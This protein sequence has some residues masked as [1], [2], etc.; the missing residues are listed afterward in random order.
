VAAHDACVAALANGAHANG[1][2][3]VS[4][5]EY[6][7]GGGMSEAG[8]AHCACTALRGMHQPGGM[9]CAPTGARPTGIAGPHT[10]GAALHALRHQCYNSTMFHNVNFQCAN[11]DAWC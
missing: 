5:A 6:D 2:A 10:F 8:G 1:V 4:P 11:A 3:R 9:G 7:P